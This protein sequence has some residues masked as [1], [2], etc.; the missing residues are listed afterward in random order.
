ME[1]ILTNCFWLTIV[2]EYHPECGSTLVRQNK[3]VKLED[4][5]FSCSICCRIFRLQSSCLMHFKRTHL[6]D[7]RKDKE[8][9]RKLRLK[10][11]LEGFDKYKE[12]F[13]IMY[14]LLKLEPAVRFYLRIKYSFLIGCSEL[15]FQNIKPASSTKMWTLTFLRTSM[16]GLKMELSPAVYVAKYSEFILLLPCISKEHI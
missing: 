15:S 2:S 9:K 10:K 1:I 14:F 7:R 3:I 8:F 12:T 6:N 13:W 11:S 16:L 4:G 5:T